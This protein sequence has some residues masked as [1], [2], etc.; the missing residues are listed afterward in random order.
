MRDVPEAAGAPD[1]PDADARLLEWAMRIADGLPVDW[2]SPEASDPA[3]RPISEEM[4][5][6]EAMAVL[7]R[8]GAAAGAA[9][10]EPPGLAGFTLERELGRGGSGVVYRARDE[11]LER[12]VALKVLPAEVALDAERLARAE[13]EAKLLASLNHP[14]IA[15]IHGIVEDA[16]GSRVLL[17]EYVEGRTLADRLA[18]GPLPVREAL[19]VCAQI[20][21][22]LA[23]AHEG[24]VI[25]RDLK[26]GNVMIGPHGRVKVL[27]FGLARRSGLAKEGAGALVAGTWAYVS[28]ERLAGGEDERADVFAFGAV[29]FECLAGARAFPGSAA[30]EILAAVIGREPDWSRLPPDLPAAVRALLASCLAKD[31]E[32]RLPRIDQ[33]CVVL[34]DALRALGG[35]AHATPS[36]ALVPGL[37]PTPTSFVGRAAELAEGRRALADARL[38]T[39]VGAG[40]SGKT[41]LAIELA[42]AVHARFD[43]VRFVDLTEVTG[44]ERVAD[45][46]ANALDPRDEAGRNAMDRVAG[47]IG[48]AR[49]LLVL[50]NCERVRAGVAALVR[51]LLARCAGLVVLATSREALG[52]AGERR[53]P[54]AALELPGAGAAD[55]AVLASADAVRL[56]LERARRADPAFAAD[57]SSVVAAAE[58]CRRVDGLPLAI[59][60][61]AARV[62][63]L[64]A[65]EIAARL[66][67]QLSLLR[68]P[69]RPGG[70]RHETM[71]AAIAWSVDALPDTERERWSALAVFAG[72]WDLEAAL[73][74][75]GLEDEFV[76]LDL[77]SSLAEKSLVVVEHARG[78]ATRYRLLE[79]IR[80]FALERLA[81]SG[82]ERVVRL[83]HRAHFV[84]LAERSSAL[85]YGPDQVRWITRLTRELDNFAAV[86][87]G[88]AEDAAGAE[89]AL[90]LVGSIHRLWSQRGL[91]I[92][93]EGC[94]RRALARADETTP[95]GVH[96]RALYGLA[97]LLANR[98]ADRTEI[99]RVL[100]RAL[101]R[102]RSAGLRRQEANCLVSLGMELGRGRDFASA[103]ARFEEALAIDR[104]LGHDEGVAA[105]LNN[106]GVVQW[107]QGDLPAALVSIRDAQA[108]RPKTADR[109]NEAIRAVSIAF[110]SLRLG[111]RTDARDA[112]LEALA[113]YER[114]G[115]RDG[116][117][118]GVLLAAAEYLLETGEPAL[119]A[120]LYGA[121]DALLSAVQG[122][123]RYVD[124]PWDRR[125]EHVARL[126]TALGRDGLARELAAGAKLSPADALALAREALDAT[127]PSIDASAAIP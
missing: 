35:E 47:T 52:A 25:H 67:R 96:G 24:G 71:R 127:A 86:L 10:E 23:A 123:A 53:W 46:I 54:L 79:P 48:G 75:C 119:A 78:E 106:L 104:E 95:P 60:L 126:E 21:E 7:V 8:G 74:V 14:N 50:D 81:A 59:E 100:E 90:R 26:P 91:T 51:D 103:R 37:P 61:A 45:A 32:R 84:A 93:G 105:V 33:A 115:T 5:T 58:I 76:V 125:S 66:D 98:N 30:D 41:R 65:S 64:S 22:A 111:R 4:K 124:P 69:A 118:A 27:D 109:T 63:V 42:R 16:R 11:R 39:L 72:G 94:A 68:D 73:A 38:V 31:P 57:A 107:M 116:N 9:V 17:L 122:D 29:L 89:P 15:T 18:A 92:F 20:A 101:E 40:G 97:R 19:E 99:T 62:R 49:V 87:D 83:R 112:I 110:L 1:A 55:P 85:T 108:L 34:D 88:C 6:L 117:A 120:R 114:A 13:R 12:P 43:V 56:F 80:Q 77:L 28:P 113:H 102:F 121:E 36:P 70:D 2:A 82:T 3:L 44:D